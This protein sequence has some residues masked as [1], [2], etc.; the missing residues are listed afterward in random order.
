L[1]PLRIVGGEH[2]VFGLFVRPYIYPSVIIAVNLGIRQ[3]S[4]A[5]KNIDSAITEGYSVGTTSWQTSKW[6]KTADKL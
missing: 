3:G 5:C 4:P 6:V 2:N 1:P